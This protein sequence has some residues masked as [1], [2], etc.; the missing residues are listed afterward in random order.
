MQTIHVVTRAATRP[1]VA[2]LAYTIHHP[3]GSMEH[4]TASLAGCVSRVEGALLS[5]TEALR[6]ADPSVPTLLRIASEGVYVVLSDATPWKPATSATIGTLEARTELLEMVGTFHDLRVELL[7][8]HAE[9]IA[10]LMREAEEE[11]E[12]AAA[13]RMASLGLAA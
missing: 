1:G 5:V 7:H 8:Q 9:E 6:A 12:A 2:A 13:E 4:V 10:P 11:A 3:N